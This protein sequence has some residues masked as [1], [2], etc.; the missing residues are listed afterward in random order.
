MIKLV[1]MDASYTGR[2]I[3][4][5]TPLPIKKIE[6]DELGLFK[7]SQQIFAKP[8]SKDIGFGKLIQDP[9]KRW[10]TLF[11]FGSHE[12]AVD[13]KSIPYCN[14]WDCIIF[15][16]KNHDAFLDFV[17]GS[18]AFLSSALLRHEMKEAM[19]VKMALEEERTRLLQSNV[20]VDFLNRHNKLWHIEKEIYQKDPEKL[21]FSIS[22]LS[23]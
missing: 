7:E 23:D 13:D 11:E 18:Q 4:S 10:K 19:A 17:A 6:L 8:K 3:H 9:S 20:S 1:H 22:E 15:S 2:K 5:C 12:W 16:K 14:F 21:D